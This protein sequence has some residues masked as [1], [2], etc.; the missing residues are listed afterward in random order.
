MFC[1]GAIHQDD[2]AVVSPDLF[3]DPGLV[4]L[5]GVVAVLVLDQDKVT[6]LERWEVARVP[7][8]YLLRRKLPLAVSLGPLVSSQSPVSSWVELT[9]L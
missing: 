2:V 5:P 7:G 8:Q 4:P 9:R 6:L 3:N 1:F